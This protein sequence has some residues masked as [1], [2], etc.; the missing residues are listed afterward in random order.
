[1]SRDSLIPPMDFELDAENLNSFE[2][3]LLNFFDT[4][5]NKSEKLVQRFEEFYARKNP[6]A[7]LC[8]VSIFINQNAS[9]KKF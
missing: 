7:L 5:V 4:K 9:V 2:K 3:Q 6:N 1:M 8:G